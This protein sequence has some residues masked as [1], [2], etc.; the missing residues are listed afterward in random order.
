MPASI[1]SE[2][3][4]CT[5]DAVSTSRPSRSAIVGL[6]LLTLVYCFAFVDR[7][8]LNLMVTVL[9]RD[10]AITD[11]QSG[12]L[13]GPAFTFSYVALGIPAGWCADRFNRRS[14]LVL[15]GVIWGLATAAAAFV[16]TYEQLFVSRMIVGASEAFLFPAGMSLIADMFARRHLPVANAVFL[17]SPYVGGG[18]A[19]I[20]GGLLLEATSGLGIID[21]PALSLLFGSVR[22]WQI[23]F[24]II[25]LA[26][27]VPVMLLVF[28]KE[29]ERGQ[30]GRKP[31]GSG[32]EKRSLV[33][34]LAFFVREWRFYMM[35]FVGAASASLIMTTASAWAPTYL[36]R[37]FGIT[38]GQIGVSYGAIMLVCGLAGGI[39]G[40]TLNA[41]VA[42]RW[43]GTPMRTVC[44][45]PML[46]VAAGLL[47]LNA[48][49]ATVALIALAIITFAYSFPLSLLGA[50]LQSATPSNLRGLAAAVYFIIGSLISQGLGPVLVP[51]ISHG[52]FGGEEAVG[53]ALAVIAM[54]FGVVA[55]VVLAS[56]V[57]GFENRQTAEDERA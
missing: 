2:T 36:E 24:L 7:Q 15:A 48:G 50:S 8:I 19:L 51:L 33:S 40:P 44:L 12:Y 41:F 47:L 38:S 1:I 46:H 35:F 21:V 28:L 13:L 34:G 9:R 4:A 49:S 27:I 56:A 5:A 43:S 39:L 18:L 55:F 57:R 42:K 23:T 22:S 20:G 26:G 6:L 37:S 30:F 52:L 45:A 16:T 54:G 10:F 31:S 25:G 3:P 53:S 11:A 32:E 14:M 29:P 17:S